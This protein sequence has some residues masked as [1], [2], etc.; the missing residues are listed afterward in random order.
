MY[1]DVDISL[2][3]TGAVLGLYS[4]D[5]TVFPISIT[6]K[7]TAHAYSNGKLNVY[8]GPLVNLF[9]IL[10]PDNLGNRTSSDAASKLNILSSP[11]GGNLVRRPLNLR[12]NWGWKDASLTK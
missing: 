7:K 12:S 8:H 9:A 4:V 10:I 3:G 5:A 6:D 2:L 11:Q 1:S